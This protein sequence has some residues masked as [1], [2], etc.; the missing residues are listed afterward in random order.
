[1]QNETLAFVKYV[2][3]KNSVH[4]GYNLEELCTHA[5][6]LKERS[7]VIKEN[8]QVQNFEPIVAHYQR[9]FIKE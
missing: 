6:F 7:I 3:E 8:E 4:S 2:L 1:M 9:P 5:E